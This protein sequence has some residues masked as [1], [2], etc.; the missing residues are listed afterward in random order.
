VRFC[1]TKHCYIVEDLTDRRNGATWRDL[2]LEKGLVPKPGIRYP[3]SRDDDH[4]LE[5]VETD[6]A[7]TRLG[8][9]LAPQPACATQVHDQTFACPDAAWISKIPAADPTA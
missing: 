2:R 7:V 4:L 8:K 9:R 1:R 3:L 6:D 5:E